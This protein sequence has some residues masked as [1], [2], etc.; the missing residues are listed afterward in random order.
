MCRASLTLHVVI[1]IDIVTYI[2]NSILLIRAVF[3]CKICK[4][5]FIP[6]IVDQHLSCFQFRAKINKTA[7]NIF[8]EVFFL[9]MCFHISFE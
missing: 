3:D 7:L 4:C 9:D 1:F 5:L 8:V 6:S 2:N